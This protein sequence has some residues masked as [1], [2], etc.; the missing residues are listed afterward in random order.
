MIKVNVSYSALLFARFTQQ[1]VKP[2]KY[3]ITMQTRKRTP[4]VTSVRCARENVHHDLLAVRRV[5][6]RLALRV[7]APDVILRAKR[8]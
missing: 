3:C 6:D 8:S 2:K 1:I 5:G 4:T 7:R